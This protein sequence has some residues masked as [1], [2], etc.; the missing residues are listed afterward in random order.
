MIRPHDF[1]GIETAGGMVALAIASIGA[2]CLIW[3]L[4]AITALS[5]A[6]II[7]AAYLIVPRL[8]RNGWGR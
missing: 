3:W 1:D 5:I 7:C 6:C 4:G 2:G 8:A